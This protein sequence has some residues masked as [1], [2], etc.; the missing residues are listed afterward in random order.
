LSSLIHWVS[1]SCLPPAHWSPLSF[2]HGCSDTPK[3]DH[4]DTSFPGSLWLMQKVLGLGY[5]QSPCFLLRSPVNNPNTC[6]LKAFYRVGLGCQVF[7]SQPVPAWLKSLPLCTSKF[8][9]SSTSLFFFF[10]FFS[11]WYWELLGK[12]STN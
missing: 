5:V 12:Y 8:P 3:L 7:H 2:P 9:S 1:S 4:R 11:L 6:C 10:F